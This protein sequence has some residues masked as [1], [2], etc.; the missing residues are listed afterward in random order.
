M[1]IY[2]FL[3]FCSLFGFNFVF[4]SLFFSVFLLAWNCM[5]IFGFFISIFG[6]FL[7]LS[8]NYF[9]YYGI[10]F[11]IWICFFLRPLENGTGFCRGRET[12]QSLCEQIAGDALLYS[13]FRENA[14]PVDCPLTGDY[15]NSLFSHADDVMQ[16]KWQHLFATFFCFAFD[17]RSIYVHVQ[18]WSRWMQESGFKYRKL[19][20]EESFVASV[21]SVPWCIWYRKYR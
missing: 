19:H 20:R 18:S 14:E 7:W 8:L 5:H 2:I 16:L 15:Y 1:T 13:L 3:C 4:Y 9:F 17:C 21:A 11:L 12:L 6:S 10:H